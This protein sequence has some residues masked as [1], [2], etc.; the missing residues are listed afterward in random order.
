MAKAQPSTGERLPSKTRD[1]V[2]KE[3]KRM[4]ESLL[5]SSKSHFEASSFWGNFHLWIGVPTVVLASI[6][7]A[8]ALSHFDPTHIFAGLLSIIGAVLSAVS[9]F[10]NPNERQSAHLNAGNSYDS[11]KDEI[12]IFRCVDCWNDKSE[13]VLTE[14]LKHYSEQKG[15]L[16]RKCPQPPPWAYRAA[17]RG[18][19]RGEGEFAV[20]KEEPLNPQKKSDND[21]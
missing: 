18:I 5:F 20:D 7:G 6:A 10:L 14:R 2:I 13:Q 17:R 9:T 21:G 16:N 11:L 15:E 1:E 12:R 4:E 3:A 8:A 19:E